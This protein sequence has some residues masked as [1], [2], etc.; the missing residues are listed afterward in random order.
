MNARQLLVDIHAHMPPLAAL[1]QLETA[2]AERR[3]PGA[4]HSIAEIVAH[5]SYWQEW[6]VRRCEGTADAMPAPAARGW[7]AVAAGSWPD[8]HARFTRGLERAA[9]L[10]EDANRPLTPPIEFPPLAGYTVHD[11]LVHM[12]QHNSHHLG[13]VILLRQMM[14]QWPPPS[15]AW[16]W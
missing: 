4:P 3:V 13:Q 9:A 11:A 12:A 14:G 16:T 10:G 7:P 5:M 6:F 8:V 1:D 2:E 15:G